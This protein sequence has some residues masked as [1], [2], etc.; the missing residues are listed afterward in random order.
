MRRFFHRLLN[1]FRDERADAEAAREIAA[2]LAL[3]EDEYLRRGM[4]PDEARLAARR[5][6]GSS[7][8]AKDRH[9]DARAFAWI[10]DARRDLAH[11]LRSLRR[12]PGF[13]AVAVVTLSLGI[14]AN[15]AIFSVISG[16]LL[17]PLP[18]SDADRLVQVFA[19]DSERGLPRGARAIPPGYF[20]ALRAPSR[21]LSHV[22]GYILTSATLTGQGDAVRLAGLQITASAFP[23]LGVAPLLGR[24]FT[25]DEESAGADAVVVLSHRTWQRYFNSDPAIVGRV[26][27]FDGRGRTIVGVM[28]EDFAFPDAFVRYWVPYVRQNPKGRSFLSLST[29]ARMRDGI[30]LSAAEDEVNVLAR[31]ADAQTKGRFEAVGLHDEMVATVKPA[32]LILA[33][34]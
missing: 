31:T 21:S 14:G 18:Y 24:P 15:T 27:S 30:A 16:V 10:D 7:A 32:L 33:A 17:R 11:G 9:R 13:T 6:L 20:E 19:P 22:A 28:P 12:A 1:A 3:L 23:M 2:H 34:A 8:L 26:A 4:E 5:A 29:V 25:A